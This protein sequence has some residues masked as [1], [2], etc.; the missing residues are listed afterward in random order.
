MFS[1]VTFTLVRAHC[2]TQLSMAESKQK[3]TNIAWWVFKEETC[4]HLE[5]NH[6]MYVRTVINTRRENDTVGIFWPYRIK[7]CLYLIG[8]QMKWKKHSE[9]YTPASQRRERERESEKEKEKENTIVPCSVMGWQKGFG[10]GIGISELPS[11]SSCWSLISAIFF[12]E[13][14][15]KVWGRGRKLVGPPVYISLIQV[16]GLVPYD[17]L[18]VH[19]EWYNSL[20]ST[21]PHNSI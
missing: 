4:V 11:P 8:Y 7:I 20:L 16:L 1:E 19:F 13:N 9:N 14:W 6:L 17:Q 15:K 3:L 10:E 5:A 18:M 12:W 21:H 2:L